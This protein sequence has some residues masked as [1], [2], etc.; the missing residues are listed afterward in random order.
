MQLPSRIFFSSN[1]SRLKFRFFLSTKTLFYPISSIPFRPHFFYFHFMQHALWKRFFLSLKT[2][3]YPHLFYSLST[4]KSSYFHF[5]QLTLWKRYFFF[6]KNL[7]YLLSSIPF[8][9]QFLYFHVMHFSLWKRSFHTMLSTARVIVLVVILR[10]FVCMVIFIW[11]LVN[12]PLFLKFR[13]FLNYF[14]RIHRNTISW[15]ETDLN[16][17]IVCWFVWLLIR[18]FCPT[19]TMFTLDI[20]AICFLRGVPSVEMRKCYVWVGWQWVQPME[21]RRGLYSVIFKSSFPSLISR[22]GFKVRPGLEMV[23]LDPSLPP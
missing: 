17:Q 16:L 14:L 23:R 8:R 1:Y 15:R 22:I 18:Q 3:F 21:S 4:P 7:F 11:W 12:P 13:H 5:M 2:L 19:L 20:S 9:P 10:S 6:V